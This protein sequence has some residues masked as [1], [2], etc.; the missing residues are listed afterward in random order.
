MCCFFFKLHI[1]IIP[2]IKLV[3]RPLP[4]LQKTPILQ[5]HHMT[6][7]NIT[8]L[9]TPVDLFVAEVQPSDLWHNDPTNEY[10]KINMG[11]CGGGEGTKGKTL[12]RLDWFSDA[13]EDPPKRKTR[14]T[15]AEEREVEG[16]QG[17]KMKAEALRQD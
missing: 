12:Q 2:C 3:K 7:G 11:V 6:L 5:T 13:T 9:I 4:Y 10:R 16:K 14:F 8:L 1:C 15:E 17:I